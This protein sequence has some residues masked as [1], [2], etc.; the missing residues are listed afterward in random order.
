MNYIPE[1]GHF[2]IGLSI[3]IPIIYLTDGKFNKKVAII[4]LLNNWLGPDHGQVF[5]KLL[6]LEELTGLDFHW[7]LP[8]LLWAIP[9]AY[10]YSYFSRFSVKRTDNFFALSDEK[11]REVSWKNAYLLCIS[12]GLLHTIA[13]AFFRHR[14]YDSTIKILNGVIKPEIGELNNLAYFGIDIGVSHILLTYF[15][16][17]FV[18]F[19]GLYILDK[20]FKKVFLFYTVYV[21]VIFCITFFFVGSEYDT[22]VV[23]LSVSFILLPLML[24]FYVDKEVTRNPTSIK[25]EPRIEAEKGLKIIGAISLFLATIFILFGLALLVSPGILS[26]LEIAEVF[27]IVLGIFVSSVGCIMA[28]GAIGLFLRKNVCRKI[29]MGASLL[30]LILIY[31][32]FIFFYIAQDDVKALFRKRDHS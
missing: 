27:I 26:S 14:V 24:L 2:I 10:F 9:L 19:F 12:G 16:A 5:S 32:L 22:A 21:A 3:I 4:F 17:I 6:S 20:E 30:M 15:I 28:I 1:A 25:K 13:D 29:L 11:R 7:F 23:I 18:V 31:P 8:F